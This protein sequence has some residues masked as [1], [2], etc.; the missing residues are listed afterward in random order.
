M[1]PTSHVYWSTRISVYLTVGPLAWNCKIK[2]GQAQSKLQNIVDEV[3]SSCGSLVLKVLSKTGRTKRQRLLL[4]YFPFLYLVCCSK[5]LFV[6]LQ[7][8]QWCVKENRLSGCNFQAPLVS[9]L[10]KPLPWHTP[11]GSFEKPLLFPISL[12]FWL[13]YQISNI[14]DRGP[15]NWCKYNFFG[16]PCWP[17]ACSVDHGSHTYCR[18]HIEL[19]VHRWKINDLAVVNE[20][21]ISPLSWKDHYWMNFKLAL[22]SP[23]KQ[24]VQII[25]STSTDWWI[26]LVF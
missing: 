16:M 25:W 8:W 2:T 9:S 13:K 5:K 3:W 11:Y 23:R 20:T 18:E 10:A 24:A 22:I 4:V 1:W 15:S 17:W 19:G 21:K 12:L 7:Y 14:R 6:L 26:Q